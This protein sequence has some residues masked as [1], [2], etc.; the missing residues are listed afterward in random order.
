MRIHQY[1]ELLNDQN[2]DVMSKINSIIDYLNQVGKLSND[3]VR[4][5]NTVYQWLMNDGLTTGINNKLEDML[6]KGEFNTIISTIVAEIGDLTTLTTNQKDTIVHAINSI[7][8]QVTTNTTNITAN[9]VQLAQKASQSD[10]SI[11]QNLTGKSLDSYS[12]NAGETDDTGLVQRALNDIKNAGI[13]SLYIPDGKIYIITTLLTIPS[14]IRIWGKGTI[15]VKDGVNGTSVMRNVDQ[16]NGNVNIVI[17]GITIDGNVANV[18]DTHP[19]TSDYRFGLDLR[20]VKNVQITNVTINNMGGDGIYFG[21]GTANGC[22]NVLVD[23]V[24]IDNA[25]RN[26][27]SIIYGNHITVKNCTFTNIIA[28]SNPGAGV[29]IEPN[30]GDVLTNVLIEDNYAY[31]TVNGFDVWGVASGVTMGDIVLRNNTTDSCGQC[32]YLI[33]SINDIVIENNKAWHCAQHGMTLSYTNRAQITGNTIIDCNTSNGNYYGIL[34]YQQNTN[35]MV[36]ANNVYVT[37]PTQYQQTNIYESGSGGNG[38]NTYLFNILYPF[39]TNAGYTS[40]FSLTTA[41]AADTMNIRYDSFPNSSVF[42]LG[43]RKWTYSDTNPPTGYYSKGDVCWNSNPNLNSVMGWVCTVSGA[44]ATWVQIAKVRNTNSGTASIASGTTSI[45]V[46][47]NLPNTPT[48][49]IATPQGNIGNVWVSGINS[50]QFTIN[51]SI[52]PGSNTNVYWKVED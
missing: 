3:V 32:G 17:E 11:I 18:V 41:S 33:S 4:D 30:T 47:H 43:N 51:C 25:G 6:A 37:D 45:V 13:G 42:K 5:W 46:T 28:P 48:V 2:Q 38:Y 34:L 21:K 20:N 27:I 26:G 14:N 31:N 22:I 29:D 44:P 36:K 7:E 10:L 24:N 40:G 52:A 9:T 15:K 19:T 23:K 1:N 50:T 49:V 16:V 35:A 39:R 8:S 12:R